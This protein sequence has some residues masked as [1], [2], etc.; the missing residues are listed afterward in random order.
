MNLS[1]K[2]EKF[3]H[4]YVKCGNGSK[5]AIAVGYAPK[6]A[7]VAA[8]RL[9]TND[10]IKKRIEELKANL[11]ETCGINRVMIVNELKKV[12]FSNIADTRTSWM[13]L[14]DF[15]KLT[16]DQKAAIAEIHH[17]TRGRVKMVKIKLHS[18]ISAIEEINK[19]LGYNAPQ[20]H[21]LSGRDGEP[22][23]IKS[24]HSVDFLKLSTE[25]L[26]ALLSA[27]VKNA[28]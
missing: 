1:V 10:N 6:S 28:T 7:R 20:Q 8:S 15:K 3:C 12:V 5:A 9:L 16:D 26:D 17:E 22:L 19:M 13:T 14:K 24:A 23:S 11:E 27:R 4:E 25:T 18:K 2:L 21:E